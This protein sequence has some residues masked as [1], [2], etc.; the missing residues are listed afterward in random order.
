MVKNFIEV[1]KMYYL[2]IDTIKEAIS[3]LLNL[4][5]KKANELYY[6][7]I[8]KYGGLSSNSSIDLSD[9]KTKKKLLE[10][11]IELSYLYSDKSYLSENNNFR[12]PFKLAEQSI[13]ESIEVWT[14]DRL[15]NN[16]LG[17]GRK[18]RDL[19]YN[20]PNSQNKIQLANNYLDKL[21]YKDK[22]SIAPLVIWINRNKSFDKPHSMR[23]MIDKFRSDFKIST[24]EFSD[25]FQIKQF[26][27]KFSGTPPNEKDILQAILNP[28]LDLKN[29][30]KL[31]ELCNKLNLG[32]NESYSDEGVNLLMKKIDNDMLVEILKDN[33]QLILSG[34]PGTSKSFTVN[35][36]SKTFNYELRK[37]Q[38][39]PQY[40]YQDFILGKTI[41]DGNVKIEKGILLN[42]IDEAINNPKKNY[43]L[44]IEEFNR[45]NVSQVFGEA[46][47]LLD[48][49]EELEFEL[50]DGPRTYSLPNNLHI[51]ATMNSTDRTLGR[52]D[53]ALRRRFYHLKFMIDYD[54][55]NTVHISD[56]YDVSLADFLA[57]LNSKLVSTLNN[58][59]MQIG[60]AI[61]LKSF[62]YDTDSKEWLWPLQKF[63]LF[64]E[65]VIKPL[66][67][68]FCNDNLSKINS[69]L[70]PKY[71]EYENNAIQFIDFIKNYE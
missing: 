61:F 70:G 29:A 26:N 45:A 31:T 2:H 57:K 13:S 4:K 65:G 54:I 52:L 34:V 3:E 38:F 11:N 30:E 12:N 49:G 40:T 43:L 50:E 53:Y 1:S 6:V 55:L 51:V 63:E 25:L 28:N 64:F 62:V 37:I 41:K 14:K 19:I 36:I 47:Q 56:N 67:S 7:M 27:L 15:T 46:I 24:K 66:I 68:E 69:I 59:D 35:E 18:W 44:A 23:G 71:L 48:R 21:K 39:H 9:D 42:Y 16:I 5:V 22:I 60:H 58:Q 33:K 10:G 17:G 32:V 8:L 20:L